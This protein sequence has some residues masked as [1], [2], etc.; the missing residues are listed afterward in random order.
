[1]DHVGAQD[2]VGAEQ[3]GGVWWEGVSL[4]QATCQRSRRAQLLLWRLQQGQPTVGRA[5]CLNPLVLPWALHPRQLALNASRGVVAVSA[6]NALY[7]LDINNPA[8]PGEKSRGVKG[9]W[10]GWGVRVGC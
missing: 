6:V 5:S 1:M 10:L 7:L 2:K 8:A 4:W 9:C 3:S